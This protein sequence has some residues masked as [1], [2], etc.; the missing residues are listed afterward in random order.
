MKSKPSHPGTST[1]ANTTARCSHS[2]SIGWDQLNPSKAPYRI[3][4]ASLKG[5]PLDLR[6]PGRH[7][8][9]R[10]RK[11]AGRVVRRTLECIGAVVF[12]AVP[13]IIVL[14]AWH[15]LRAIPRSVVVYGLGA[16]LTLVLLCLGYEILRIVLARITGWSNRR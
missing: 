3:T 12:A 4:G 14:V 2:A 16:Y 15:A 5:K 1:A 9:C 7:P 13:V 8:T 10:G 11:G 6:L